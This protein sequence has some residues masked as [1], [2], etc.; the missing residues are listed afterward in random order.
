VV[1]LE[2]LAVASQNG[3]PRPQAGAQS[4]EASQR[5]Q[6]AT[7]SQQPYNQAATGASTGSKTPITLQ[8][9]SSRL[10]ALLHL[11]PNPDA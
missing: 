7:P 3:A 11:L 5:D 6:T 10:N 1:A 4:T 2:F 9:H 8:C